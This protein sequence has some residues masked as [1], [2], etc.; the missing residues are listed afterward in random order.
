M[1]AYF[2]SF[3]YIDRSYA[4]VQS[5][6]VEPPDHVDIDGDTIDYYCHSM[7][8]EYS[9]DSVNFLGWSL[10]PDADSHPSRTA[11]YCYIL[12]YQVVYADGSKWFVDTHTVWPRPITTLQDL[13][14]VEDDVRS[15]CQAL[16]ARAL[17]C[18]PVARCKD[19]AMQKHFE[20]F[21]GESG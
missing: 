4:R 7:K 13:R 8:M 10:L 6:V 1:P 2:L 15:D 18:L 3:S 11:P 19:E 9:V 12:G 16:T 5:H 20:R 17:S 21:R 14:T